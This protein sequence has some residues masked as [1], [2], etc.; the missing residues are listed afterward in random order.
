[1]GRWR[2]WGSGD[3]VHWYTLD[4]NRAHK[5]VELELDVRRRVRAVITPDDPDMVAAII[6]EHAHD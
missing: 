1:M 6:S 2:F 4:G 5:T 3:F